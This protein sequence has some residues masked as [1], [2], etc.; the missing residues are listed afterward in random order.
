M[1]DGHEE[2]N[3]ADSSMADSCEAAGKKDY[4]ITINN[5]R[6]L[7]S[8]TSHWNLWQT[9]TNCHLQGAYWRHSESCGWNIWRIRAERIAKILRCQYTSILSDVYCSFMKIKC[10]LIRFPWSGSVISMKLPALYMPMHPEP[11]YFSA[12]DTICYFF[13]KIFYLIILIFCFF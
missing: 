8:C 3:N 2:G 13:W 7:H 10:L 6:S 5:R 4:K 12:N 11:L 1:A 9:C